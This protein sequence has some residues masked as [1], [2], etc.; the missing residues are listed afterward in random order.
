MELPVINEQGRATASIVASDALFGRE[1]NE[2]LVHQLVVASP[3]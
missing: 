2:A 3:M 1:Y